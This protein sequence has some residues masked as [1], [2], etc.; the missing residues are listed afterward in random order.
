MKWISIKE[1]LPEPNVK[2][3]LSYGLF[4]TRAAVCDSWV[5][6]GWLT[7]SGVWSIKHVHGV[8]LDSKPTHWKPIP[9][10]PKE[11]DNG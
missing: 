1:K 5:T 8:T 3:R 6:T 9:Q 2:V 7:K 4:G 10:P 11:K